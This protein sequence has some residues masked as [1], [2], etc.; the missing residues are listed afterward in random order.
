MIRLYKLRENVL[1][2]IAAGRLAKENM[3]QGWI[4]ERPE[5]LGLDQLLI[6]GREVHKA[7]AAVLLAVFVLWILY[8][9]SYSVHYYS[10]H[11]VGYRHGYDQNANAAS[12]HRNDISY[13]GHSDP[14]VTAATI[15]LVIVGGIQIMVFLK[16]LYLI[17]A[18]LKPAEDAAKAANLNAQAVIDAER[19]YIF[20]GGP[21][22]KPTD[23]I[24]Y[25]AIENDGRTPGFLKRVDW[26]LCDEEA[27]RKVD[28]PVNQIIERGLLVTTKIEIEDVY[29]PSPSKGQ[30]YKEIEFPRAPNIGKI[31]FGRFIY[32]DVFGKERRYSTFK[33][34][35]DKERGSIPLPGC[36]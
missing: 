1:L 14:G 23:T 9:A 32:D 21:Y 28:V 36:Y 31:F 20:G 15:L 35:L 16:Q 25:G 12:D 10:Y 30:P 2:P 8:S 3:I 24:W 7:L 4:E 27:F 34:K 11:Y 19:A 26:G 5:L 18:G 29:P 22:G 6:I 33:L 17:R 13:W